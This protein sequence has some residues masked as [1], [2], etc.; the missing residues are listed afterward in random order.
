MCLN[1]NSSS[2]LS[3]KCGT[4]VSAVLTELQALSMKL[5]YLSAVLTCHAKT[6]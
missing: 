1:S 6:R 5:D 2:L 3:P 4:R